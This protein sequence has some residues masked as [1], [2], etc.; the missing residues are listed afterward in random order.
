M[1]WLQSS[2]LPMALGFLT[3]CGAGTSPVPVHT[4]NPPAQFSSV[5][6][7][8]EAAVPSAQL[9]PIERSEW[10]QHFTAEHVMGTIALLDTADGKLLCN[11]VSLCKKPTIPASTFKIANSMIALES[12]VVQ[13]AETLLRWDG[14]YYDVPEWN[15]DNTLRTAVQVSCVP[16]FQAIARAVG[17]QQMQ[18]WLE[19]LDYGNR[20]SAGG[21]DQFWLTGGLRISP[22]QQ[23]GFLR[24]FDSGSLPISK[25]TA[26]TVRALITLD[27]GQP[28]A[29]LGKTGMARPPENPELA[30]WCVG[31]LELGARRVYFATLINTH[32]P[33]I[34]PKPS[35]RAVTERVL[36]SI[37]ALPSDAARPPSG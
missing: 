28:H 33:G 11:D 4:P 7:K 25:R 36:R 22:V 21:I 14:H 10:N 17:E 9:D 30:A 37:Q 29:L 35:R 27:V 3:G 5:P 26:D 34:D 1:S 2:A 12:G 31:W 6:H 8:V 18:G 32:D 20:S 15:R 16:C 13:D 23:I 24:R 19:K